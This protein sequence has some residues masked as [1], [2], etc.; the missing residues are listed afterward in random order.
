MLLFP[1][2]THLIL[3]PIFLDYVLGR[4]LLPES[5]DS[6]TLVQGKPLLSLADPKPIF[7]LAVS[8][9]SERGCLNVHSL[10]FRRVGGGHG[11]V[12]HTITLC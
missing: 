5:R 12:R 4:R 1:S 7:V 2:S 11:S 3:V 10:A 9:H 6:L 8:A